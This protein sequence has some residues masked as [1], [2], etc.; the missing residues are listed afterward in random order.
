MTDKLLVDDSLPEDD[1]GPLADL[2]RQMRM[3]SQGSPVLVPAAEQAAAAAEAAQE[4]QLAADVAAAA[5]AGEAPLGKTPRTAVSMGYAD[6]H[7]PAT[8]RLLRSGGTTRLLAE[9]DSLAGD[10]ADTRGQG[11][12]AGGPAGGDNAATA[13]TTGTTKLLADMTMA[14]SIGVKLLSQQGE[15][16]GQA[17]RTARVSRSRRKELLLGQAIAAAAAHLPSHLPALPR[18]PVLRHARAAPRVRRRQRPHRLLP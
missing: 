7:N 13:R 12:Q 5:S 2:K 11:G 6:S 8:L 9:A 3:L 16:A 17:G 15:W 10:E 4:Q 1:V 18:A 14:S